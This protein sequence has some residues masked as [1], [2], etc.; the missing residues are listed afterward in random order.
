MAV[1]K[2]PLTLLSRGEYKNVKNNNMAP[3][4]SILEQLC[5][6]TFPLKPTVHNSTPLKVYP[7]PSCHQSPQFYV[8]AVAKPKRNKVVTPSL[9][10]VPSPIKREN[11][12]QD[13]SPNTASVVFISDMPAKI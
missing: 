7:D 8:K 3:D 6:M 12:L 10:R 9:T 11:Q 5:Q 2:Y 13:P 4:N 1:E